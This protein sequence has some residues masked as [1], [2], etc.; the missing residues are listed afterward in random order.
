MLH[1]TIWTTHPITHIHA[2]RR[3]RSRRQ[4]ERSAEELQ[5]KGNACENHLDGCYRFW[6]R[7]VKK[8]KKVDD[9]EVK[10]C[11]RFGGTA[12]YSFS[13]KWSPVFNL[14]FLFI[15]TYW[16]WWFPRILRLQSDWFIGALRD[17]LSARL[18]E[19]CRDV[20]SRRCDASNSRP[21]HISRRQSAIEISAAMK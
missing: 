2:P 3:R 20:V 18:R 14:F 7:S 15:F 17:D 12:C 9:Q 21:M 1:T 6:V 8:E 10:I 11:L 5:E 4:A 13:V 16:N 19:K